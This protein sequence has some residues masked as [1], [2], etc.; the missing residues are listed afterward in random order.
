MKKIAGYLSLLLCSGLLLT[1]VWAAFTVKAPAFS[2]Q[3]GV[4]Q[5]CREIDTLSRCDEAATNFSF[6]RDV[7]Q[8]LFPVLK[9]LN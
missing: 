5:T 3:S 6:F 4:V 8:K 2:R 7:A 1:F 9:S